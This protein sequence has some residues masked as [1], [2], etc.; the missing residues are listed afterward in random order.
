MKRKIGAVAAATAALVVLAGCSTASNTPD[1]DE[2][3]GQDITF[4][5]MGGDTP[6]TLRD[7]LKKEY[8][9][10]TGGTLTIE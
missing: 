10:A 2:A 1:P 3:K 5:V 4:W 9:D 7:Y 6:D 8:A